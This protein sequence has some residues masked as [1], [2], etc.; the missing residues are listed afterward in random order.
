MIEDRRINYPGD[1]SSASHDETRPGLSVFWDD[2]SGASLDS[3]KVK[4]ARSEEIKYVK[5]H[6]VYDNVDEE[7]CWRI[8]GKAPIGTRWIDVNKGSEEVPDY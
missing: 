8:T 6:E 4:K 2:M 3:E 1:L 5:H 7:E